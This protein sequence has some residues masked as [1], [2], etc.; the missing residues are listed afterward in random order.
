MSEHKNDEGENCEMAN[1]GENQESE[2]QKILSYV[3]VLFFVFS[4]VRIFCVLNK[5]VFD[6]F[7]ILW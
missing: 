6:T 2:S 1:A 3:S 7:A 4:T 5:F